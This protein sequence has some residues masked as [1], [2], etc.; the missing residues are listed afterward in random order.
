MAKNKEDK[1]KSAKPLVVFAIILALSIAIGSWVY[2]IRTNKYFGLGELLRPQLK[3]IPIIC[4]I[5]PAEPAGTEPELMTRDEINK[6]YTELLNENVGLY[7]QVAD[8]G[9]KVNEYS[10]IESKYR[11]VLKELDSLSKEFTELKAKE[12]T[13]GEKD[14]TD[15]IANLVKIYESMEPA[16]AADILEDVGELNISL[17]VSICKAMKTAS[18]SEIMQEMSTDFAAILSERMAE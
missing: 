6:R 9:T 10:E 2:L 4:N 3:D 17:V 7:K 5:L 16:N 8:L 13:T 12:A 18:F 15:K 1:Q 11:I 14:N